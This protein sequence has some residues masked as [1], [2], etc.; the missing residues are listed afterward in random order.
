MARTTN[1]R[2]T[3]RDNKIGGQAQTAYATQTI[4]VGSAAAF[5]VN[6]TTLTPN[7]NSTVT[8]VVSGTTAAPYNVAN[9]KIDYTYDGGDTWTVLAASV[10]NSGSA[11]VLFLQ[12]WPGKVDI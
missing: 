6:A 3:V 11:T 8:W 1:F 7:T 12:H 2:V 10:P 4:V 5:T 9:V